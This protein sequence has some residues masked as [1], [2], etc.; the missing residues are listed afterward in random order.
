M[1]I[2]NNVSSVA[3][4]DE[5]KKNEGTA[6][7]QLIYTE[8]E[9]QELDH[10]QMVNAGRED[11]GADKGEKGDMHAVLSTR[12]QRSGKG[13]GPDARGAAGNLDEVDEAACESATTGETGSDFSVV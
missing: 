10:P 5:M 4:L 1:R 3:A 9:R 8:E 6:F 13:Q 12:E 2:M 11:D 7:V